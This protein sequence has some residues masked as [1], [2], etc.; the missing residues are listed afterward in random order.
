MY[1]LPVR[2]FVQ[3]CF[4]QAD[5]V[6]HLRN[7][8][9]GAE[10][11]SLKASRGWAEKMT[12]NPVMHGRRDLA[13]VAQSD[14]VPYFKDK[15][16]RSGTVASLRIANLPEAMSLQNRNTHMVAL[17]P[18][19]FLSWCP[20]KR[21]GVKVHKNPKNQAPLTTVLCDEL[22]DLYARGLY[23]VDYSMADGTPGRV[24]LCRCCL[25]FW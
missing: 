18:S 24:F 5:L 13:F 10:P 12:N 25:L 3:D 15:S 21:K 2:H 7:D 19:V 11:G 9:V 17:Q 20:K 16:L 23:V 1:Y 6:P 8:A 14:G 4:K 22:Y